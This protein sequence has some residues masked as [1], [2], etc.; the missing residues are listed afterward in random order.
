MLQLAMKDSFN[1]DDGVS[2]QIQK[3]GKLVKSI[4]KCTLNTE[5][6][7]RLGVRPTTG[8][9]TRW[10]IQLCMIESVLTMFE[11]HP[12]WQNKLKSTADDAKLTLNKVR[13][14]QVLAEVLTPLADL[15]KG[16]GPWA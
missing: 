4:R 14:L 10:N 8:C 1:I 2:G 7:D 5:E 13:H 11:R 12:L 16:W 3:V 15:R 6:R 9:M